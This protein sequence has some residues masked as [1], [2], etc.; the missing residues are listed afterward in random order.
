MN[1]LKARF[2][3]I[4]SA[5]FLNQVVFAEVLRWP[6][7]CTE[8]E[9]E[10]TNTLNSEVHA[11]VQTFNPGLLSEDEVIV[12]AHGLLKLKLKQPGSLT[13]HSLLHFY[14][15]NSLKAFFKCGDQKFP[16][17]SFEGGILTFQKSDLSENKL[18][19]QNIY[20]GQNKIHIELISEKMKVIFSEDLFLKSFEQ[21]SYK[22][23]LFKQPWAALR[24][25]AE[26][27]FAA[28]NLTSK[29]SEGPLLLNLQKSQVNPT[30]FY[31][32]VAP[33]ENSAESNR[34]SFIVKMTDE[35][36]AER[37]RELIANPRLEKMLFAKI[38]K[39]H[40]GF[41]RN[42]SKK[43]KSFWSWSVTRVTNFAD[44]GS[45][46]CNGGPQIV[47][48]R[49]NSWLDDPGQICFWNYRVKKELSADEVARGH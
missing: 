14:A 3:L 48:D 4:L 39:G 20:D 28:F 23:I 19:I 6:Q 2:L 30:A 10:I 40:Q 9:L 33:R 37:A 38:E 31:F 43:D 41:N 46:A 8:G 32:L 49:I 34:E 18:W 44:L 16:A 17:H 26:N 1:C 21:F 35:S 15:N 45:T 27:R 47:E 25:S 13:R 29:G 7:T 24:I 42:W 11:W 36:M 22:N 12:E 5:I